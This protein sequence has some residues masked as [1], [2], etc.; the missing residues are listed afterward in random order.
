M[1]PHPLGVLSIRT[2][3]VIL[4]VANSM[5]VAART[6]RKHTCSP[7][8]TAANMQR[9][10]PLPPSCRELSCL[11]KTRPLG[12]VIR[13]TGRSC[14]AGRKPKPSAVAVDAAA[15]A[16][17]ERGSE[18]ARANTKKARKCELTARQPPGHIA[19]M[20]RHTQAGT[21]HVCVCVCAGAG[22]MSVSAQYGPTPRVHP[23]A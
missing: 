14:A 3:T 20:P 18:G 16:S 22:S 15:A 8:P 10:H 13:P 12:A 21:P 1:P 17:R 11:D 2:K 9:Q 23:A 5:L 7:V 19:L 6:H 4:T